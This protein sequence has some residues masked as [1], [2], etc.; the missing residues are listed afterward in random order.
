MTESVSE[1]TADQGKEGEGGYVDDDDGGAHR[2]LSKDR[3]QN[4][5]SCAGHRENGRAEGHRQEASEDPHGRQGREY[6][7]GRDWQD[8]GNDG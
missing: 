1:K 4:A 3:D 7:K 5:Q 8:F 6:Y 2:S